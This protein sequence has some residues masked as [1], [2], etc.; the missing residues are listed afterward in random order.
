MSSNCSDQD[1]QQ[2]KLA[3]H[4]TQSFI[5]Q[6]PAG[7]GKTELL[8]QR[9]LTLLNVVKTPEEILAITFTKK[10]ANEMRL[11]II[12]ALKQAASNIRPD[13]DHNRKTFE[14][15]NQ[16]LTRDAK[17][18]WR[19][20]NN[21]N[22]LRIQT[23]DSL[24]AYLTKQLP[25]L[26]HFGAQ[27]QIATYP[28]FLYQEAVTEVLMHVEENYEW[29]A[30][31][32][33]LLTHVDNDFNKLCELLVSLLAKRDQWLPYIQ[34]TADAE[35]IR[36]RLEKDL[37]KVI[38]NHLTH[39]CSIFPAALGNELASI[40]RFAADQLVLDNKT[41]TMLA[42]RNL[43]ELPGMRIQ[44]Q[45][46][47]L[48]LASLLLTKKFNWRKRFDADIGF[49]AL[50]SLKTDKLEH[51]NY[52]KRL[53]ALIDT[54]SEREDIQ[55]ALTELFFLPPPFY[56]DD[57]WHILQALL[58]ILK[59]VTA[60]LRIVFQQHGQIDFIENAL[61][62]LTA[63]GSDEQPTN[64]A[65]ALDYQIRHILVDEFQDTSYT[66][67]QL[68]EKLL[69]GWEKSDGRTLFVVGD[70]MQSIYRFREAEVGLFIRMVK[71]GI[72]NVPL[73]PITLSVNFRSDTQIVE[74][75]NQHFKALFP[76]FNDVAKGAVTYSP[77]VASQSFADNTSP[78]VITGL[79]N[80]DD[81]A[82]AQHIVTLIHTIKKKH[83]HDSIAVLVRSRTHLSQIV[84]ALKQ[85]EL[86]YHAVD[87]D[88]LAERQGI[89]DVFSL[90]CALLHPADRIAW[91]SILRAPWCGLTL[92]DLLSIAGTAPYKTIWEQLN[93]PD[94]IK[95]MTQDGQARVAKFNAI[96]NK[97]MLH[98]ERYPL[99]Y[100]IENT[101]LLLGGPAC[102]QDQ[103]E[104]EDIAVFF[105][106]LEE[107][108]QS[109]E[110]LNLKKLKEK[111]Q[112]L[113]AKPQHNESL[114][115]IMT[116]HSAKGLEFDT[117][118][119]PHL[120]CNIPHD[121][122]TLLEWMEYPLMHDQMA[123][124][125]APIHSSGKKSDALYEYIRRQQK[126]KSDYET[127]RLL[128]VAATRAKKRLC[129]L[130]NF[131]KEA[132]KEVSIASGSFLEKLW[133]FI[134]NNQ[135]IFIEAPS[136]EKP[137]DRR[138][139]LKPI[140]RLHT[141]WQNPV[142]DMTNDAVV[143]HKQDGF[144]LI[145]NT[146]MLT[147]T[148]VHHLLQYISE[149]SCNWWLSKNVREQTTYI[150][151]KLAQLGM[152]DTEIKS[153]VPTVLHAMKNTLG[154]E[155]GRWILSPHKDAQS[156]LAMTACLDG[157]PENYI[158]DRTFID[159]DGIRWI[160]DYKTTMFTQQDLQQFLIKEQAKYLEKM[161]NYAR[162][163]QLTDPLPVR[164]ALYFPMLP[165][166]QL[167]N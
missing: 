86:D 129:L 2:R 55:T 58:Q 42:C 8:I 127:D 40:A 119:L 72:A 106:L 97:Q 166:L 18:Q 62:A 19:L 145:K 16:V 29:S 122:K 161:K 103:T 135:H 13:S 12:A 142:H 102:L 109:S 167:L 132:N 52:R 28:T 45:Q 39:L 56:H 104:I 43:M 162:T 75:N 159:E 82:Q 51:T 85:A 98:R 71:D 89:Q 101:W 154:D 151:L 147:G 34:L 123:L 79:I 26:S 41:S 153:A 139:Q 91:L 15:A 134:K 114:L 37:E 73:A 144:Q 50:N 148:V 27:P 20:I 46:A 113:F 3:L 138:L 116:I 35:A 68:L 83:P 152:C 63:L 149:F 131:E 48:G 115:N 108:D 47:W 136:S 67:Y 31:I 84:P 165:V 140:R 49:P 141:C 96:I 11:R 54:L 137:V 70:P 155:R 59:I 66:Q 111:I 44:D 65:L 4:P 99:R 38:T 94:I 158:L 5:V 81:A 23:I 90:T 121:Q 160:I 74:W 120:E 21:P 17:F 64:L 78:I 87:I 92:A 128:Y 77:S 36:H 110:V 6:A 133:P 143:H 88:P 33:K 57:Q 1:Q 112:Q 163:M 117:I 164:L 14:L 24:C 150:T 156:E 118:L 105:K 100:W 9:F 7:S 93:Q 25:I 126:I 146:A 125:L 61:A 22:Q 60:Q 30:A 124:L 130:F 157:P 32:G 107:C 95:T 69:T 76:S 10:A 80:A 53:T